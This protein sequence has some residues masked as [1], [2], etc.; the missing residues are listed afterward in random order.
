MR[1]IIWYEKKALALIVQ[2]ETGLKAL[3]QLFL[4][5]S[6]HCNCWTDRVHFFRFFETYIFMITIDWICV[7]L[8]DYR[9]LST[10]SDWTSKQCIRKFQIECYRASIV[11]DHKCN[12][13]AGGQNPLAVTKGQFCAMFFHVTERKRS[14]INFK[15]LQKKKC[16]VGKMAKKERTRVYTYV[17]HSQH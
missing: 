2:M 12:H 8:M 9:R 15:C 7:E 13:K 14:K 17:P 4:H 3:L 5:H 6:F 11:H 10:P 16:R 1:K